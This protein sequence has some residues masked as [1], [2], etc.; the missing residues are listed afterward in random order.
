LAQEFIIALTEHRAAGNIFVALL[1]EKERSYYTVRKVVKLRDVKSGEV[2]LS[3]PELELLKIIENYSDENLVKKFSKKGDQVNFFQNMDAELF[4][5]HISP[6]IDKHIYK[7]VLLLMKGKTR[8]YYKQA[9]YS[10]LYDEDQ[11]HVNSTFSDSV[12]YFNRDEFGTK[13]KLRISHEGKPIDLLRKTIRMVCTQPC[14]FVYLNKLYVFKG[15]S[16]KKLIPFLAKDTVSIP[17]QAEDKYYQTFV[18]NN[19]K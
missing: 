16:G 1:I 8:L 11:I 12:F 19:R 15:L 9:K 2:Q 4:Q 13:Y 14:C 6:Y 18:L 10:N 7:C 5:D 17:R 3:D